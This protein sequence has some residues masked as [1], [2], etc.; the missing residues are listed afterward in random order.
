MQILSN[1]ATAK[2]EVPQC[3]D[4]QFCAHKQNN[5]ARSATLRELELVQY[6]SN[7]VS[8]SC[9]VANIDMTIAPSFLNLNLHHFKME[10]RKKTSVAGTFKVMNGEN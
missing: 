3:E 1:I 6:L 8:G 4:T 9:N 10:N 7:D 5:V 2:N